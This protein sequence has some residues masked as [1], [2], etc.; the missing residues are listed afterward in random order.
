VGCFLT[1]IGLY[2]GV[3]QLLR[4]PRGRCSPYRGLNLWH[5][6]AG[7]VFGVFT[8]TWV[9]SGLLS[10]NPW[11][12][13]QGGD[14]GGAAARLQGALTGAQVRQTLRALAQRHPAGIASLQGEGFQGR[15]YLMATTTRGQRLRLDAQG[16]PAPLGAS[17]RAF[18]AATLGG[19]L[20]LLP[21]GDRYYFAHHSSPVLLPVY[22]VLAADGV[23]YYV[24]PLS[25]ALLSVVDAGARGY[26][27]WH[28][29]L[30]RMDFVPWLRGRPQWDVL[31]WA[32]MCGV[33]LVCMTG[34]YLG[35]RRLL[36]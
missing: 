17:E 18:I 24:D 22:R 26:R 12:W 23:R 6:L 2:L 3:R 35:M 10:M 33:T 28:Q 25:G 31:M 36:P 13:L 1:A 7:L 19:D 34:C 32:L 21:D 29:G 9:L 20:R 5:H 8:L 14:D 11:G 15:L 27:W 4:A 16:Q 30:H